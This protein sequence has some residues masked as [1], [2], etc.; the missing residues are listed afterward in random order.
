[1]SEYTK[2]D[3]KNIIEDL[4]IELKQC[5][6]DFG[7]WSIQNELNYWRQRLYWEESKLYQ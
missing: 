7:Y 4:E 6:S 5:N 2:E 3:I 1:M